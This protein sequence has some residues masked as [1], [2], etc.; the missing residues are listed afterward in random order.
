MRPVSTRC[1]ALQNI[2][3]V[4]AFGGI[5]HSGIHVLYALLQQSPLKT[6]GHSYQKQDREL[7]APAF[8]FTGTSCFCVPVIQFFACAFNSLHILGAYSLHH[9][10]Q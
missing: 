10:Y 5:L 3:V 7:E 2:Q 4:V 6:S 8:K 9:F 1:T